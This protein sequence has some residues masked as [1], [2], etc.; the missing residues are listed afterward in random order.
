V[1]ILAPRALKNDG[2][3]HEAARCL[4]LDIATDLIKHGHTPNFPS[5]LH[6]GR[7]AL[8]ELCLNAHITTSAQ[9]S[10][11]R[12]LIRLLLDNGA[13]PLFRARNE[14]ST[15][16]L[17]LDNAYSALE[18]TEALLE[19][20]VWETLND[21]KNLYRDPS[22]SLTYSPLSY[23]QL[24]PSHS[25][26][27]HKSELLSLLRDKGCEPRFYSET[28]H[29]PPG[30]IGLPKPL[31]HLADA[32]T[33]HDLALRHERERHE[34]LRTL[35]ETS[36]KDTLRRKKEQ[37]NAELAAQTAA[38]QHWQLLAQQKHEFELARVRE[39][40]HMKR[41]EKVTWHNL[42]M[43]QE[44]E[45]AG[46]KVATEARLVEERKKEVEHRAG[47]EKKML[48]DKEEVYERNVGR[49]KEVIKRADESAQL[50]ARMRQD[51]VAIEGVPQ[52]GSVD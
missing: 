42:T 3:L 33:S 7:H 12:Q 36:H 14:K 38:T 16:I 47:V 35:E 25:R 51:R 50:H 9:R 1:G 28:A 8:S 37:N 13:N 6:Q 27:P 34:H 22:T 39:A 49:Q 19:T 24:V 29:Q 17:A 11:A 45:A 48:R 23:P 32:Q 43:E 4:Q 15:V 21:E 5:R 26:A 52:W 31:R 20:E 41:G 40:E 10:K 30:A 18:V 44:R 46:R 2:S